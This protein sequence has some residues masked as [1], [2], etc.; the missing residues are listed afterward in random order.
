MAV[1][2]KKIAQ[3]HFLR[4][5]FILLAATFFNT[6]LNF[7]FQVYTSRALGPVGYGM[8]GAI[9]SLF[10]LTSAPIATITY[11]LTQFFARFKAQNNFSFILTLFWRS[12]RRFNQLG[13][14][15]FIFFVILSPQIA[16]FLK[17]PSPAPIIFLGIFLWSALFFPITTAFLSSLEN[18]KSLSLLQILATAAK[19]VFGFILISF[20]LGVNG[21]IVA[22]I[23]SSILP[24]VFGFYWL[25]PHL[26][27]KPAELDTKEIYAYSLPVFVTTLALTFFINIDLIL[28]KHFFN[29]AEAGFYAAASTLGKL[30][31]FGAAALTTAMFPKVVGQLALKQKPQILLKKAILYLLIGAAVILFFFY[32]LPDFTSGLVFG[33]QYHIKNILFPMG[34]AVLLMSLVFIL[35]TYL[36]A[37][38]QKKFPIILVFFASLEILLIWFRHNSLTQVIQNIIFCLLP[39]LLILGLVIYQETI[40]RELENA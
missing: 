8:L 16:G 21:A 27:E 15:I 19:L 2:L 37:I 6:L 34:L 24:F 33:Y 20:G 13:F 18:F 26:K 12:V 1:Q 28:V 22:L 30:I 9:F 23:I 36:L 17:F 40:Q 10:Y 3:D 31:Y 29:P 39:L 14:L 4:D 11:S 35:T 38:N 5:S 32:F 7:F 25:G